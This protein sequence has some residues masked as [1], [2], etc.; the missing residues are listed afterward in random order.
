VPLINFIS[1]FISAQNE[2]W[3]SKWQKIVLFLEYNNVVQRCII[4]RKW[5]D[6]EGFFRGRAF[7]A[8]LK[9]ERGKKK[10]FNSDFKTAAV[11]ATSVGY[12]CNPTV[13]AKRPWEERWNKNSNWE[14]VHKIQTFPGRREARSWEGDEQSLS[15]SLGGNLLIQGLL[16]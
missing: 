16:L 6:S 11:K 1:G 10:K 7:Q 5:E 2:A 3:V 13:T 8:W 15:S 4:Q 12:C 14:L 9:T